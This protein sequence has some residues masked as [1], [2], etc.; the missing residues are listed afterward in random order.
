MK[1]R[2]NQK[3]KITEKVACEANQL[4]FNEGFSKMSV[5]TELRS[6][7]NKEKEKIWMFL[8]KCPWLHDSHDPVVIGWVRPTPGPHVVLRPN[9]KQNIRTEFAFNDS[10]I[11][12]IECS[13]MLRH[14]SKLKASS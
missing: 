2:W 13:G 4:K 5:V 9:Y 11:A 7:F 12:A 3:K 8:I 6:Y 1:Y 14:S 10:W